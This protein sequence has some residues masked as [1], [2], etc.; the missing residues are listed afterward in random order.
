MARSEV[1]E[2]ASEGAQAVVLT[3]KANGAK[4]KL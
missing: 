2:G 4:K 3:K 1:V